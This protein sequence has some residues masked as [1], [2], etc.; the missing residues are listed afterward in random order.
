MQYKAHDYQAYA[1][2]FI[3]THPACGLL[4][5]IEVVYDY[6]RDERYTWM[7]PIV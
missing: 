5:D 6:I 1:S 4:L 2:E 7:S 3:I